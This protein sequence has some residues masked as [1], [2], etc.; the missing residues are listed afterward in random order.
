M[1]F[2]WRVK[3]VDMKKNKEISFIFSLKRDLKEVNSNKTNLMLK[4][5]KC[6]HHSLLFL[7]M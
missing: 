2:F 7:S 3:L 1:N 4:A 5:I 6:D